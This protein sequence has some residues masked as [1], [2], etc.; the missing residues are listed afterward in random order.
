MNS[1][2][3][4]LLALAL[5]LNWNG[6]H[7]MRSMKLIFHH[8]RLISHQVTSIFFNNMDLGKRWVSKLTISPPDLTNLGQNQAQVAF[9]YTCIVTKLCS[10]VTMNMDFVLSSFVYIHMCRAPLYRI[11]HTCHYTE[12]Y[13][14]RVSHTCKHMKHHTRITRAKTYLWYNALHTWIPA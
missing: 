12:Q 10:Q 1:S 11:T 13:F 2:K 7:G 14:T 5:A 3:V 9:I 8:V 6:K 4:R